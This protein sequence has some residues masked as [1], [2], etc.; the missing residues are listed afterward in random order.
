MAWDSWTGRSPA[1]AVVPNAV[2]RELLKKARE[3]SR[4]RREKHST[5]SDKPAAERKKED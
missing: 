2:R 1:W 5:K 4:T 3:R